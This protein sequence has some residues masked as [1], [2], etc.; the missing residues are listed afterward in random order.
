[1]IFKTYIKEYDKLNI[2]YISWS[3]FFFLTDDHISTAVKDKL[4][5]VRKICS[6]IYNIL[7]DVLETVMGVFF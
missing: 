3:F 7:V 1:M 6:I 2:F 4:I 5:T